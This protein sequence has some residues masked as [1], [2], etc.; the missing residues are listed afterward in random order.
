M[1]IKFRLRNF[2]SVADEQI[3][4]FQAAKFE[5]LPSRLIQP[6]SGPSSR[7]GPLLRSLVLYGANGS[8]KSNVV[9]A[10]QVMKRFVL[11]SATAFNL[12]DPIPDIVPFEF[13]PELRAS[14]SLF[15]VRLLIDHQV[16]TYG[17]EAR[18]TEVHS[19]WLYR[20]EDAPRRRSTLVFERRDAD[21]G[22]W[23]F[24][25]EI[26]A[27]AR[28]I[29]RDR[30]RPSNGLILSKGV[31]ENIG[32]LA[33]VYRWFRA[34]L[35]ISDLSEYPEP[36]INYYTEKIAENAE[37]HRLAEN[38]LRVADADLIGLEVS[39]RITTS[40][41]HPTTVPKLTERGEYAAKTPAV[42]L[43]SKR[44]DSDSMIR[45]LPIEEESQG[46]RRFLVM[47]LLVRDALEE[48]N[49]LIWDEPNASLHPLLLRELMEVINDGNFAKRDAQVLLVSHEENLQ[50]FGILRRDQFAFA[51]K[52][53]DHRTNLYRL[54]DFSPVVKR[55]IA[56]QLQYL[57]GRFGGTPLV[58]NL[59]GALS[60]SLHYS[61]HESSQAH[62]QK[63]LTAA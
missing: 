10:I 37:Y 8:G 31:Q 59:S 44:T 48:G 30:T 12:G 56:F 52:N 43:F 25:D 34:Q 60:D 42:G 40:G 9:K 45:I 7:V 22:K 63:K 20:Q 38:I 33:P 16:Y 61:V 21:P 11:D 19:E 53:T 36:D 55:T 1:L 5:E 23:R 18:P 24:G 4:S 47:S 62:P 39:P 29:L 2:R 6:P 26:G 41:L 49:T 27:T 32:A 15:E 28:K 54:D 51:E 3:L 17:F 58:G 46:T 57:A 35:H 14:P 13:D 50:D